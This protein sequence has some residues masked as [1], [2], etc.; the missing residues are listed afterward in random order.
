MPVSARWAAR[1]YCLRPRRISRA[2]PSRG[3]ASSALLTG[4]VT[5]AT[6]GR[7]TPARPVSTG[8]KS[9]RRSHS[10]PDDEQATPRREDHQ[11]RLGGDG[12]T[13][14]L[15]GG[16]D[17]R[18]GSARS[19]RARPPAEQEQR[20]DPREHEGVGG[21]GQQH[22]P[23]VGDHDVE[24]RAVL[25]CGDGVLG[26]RREELLHDSATGS[27]TGGSGSAPMNAVTPT[28]STEGPTPAGH[29]SAPSEAAGRDGPRSV[30]RTSCRQPARSGAPP[31]VRTR[32][33]AR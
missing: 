17:E 9:K 5:P 18:G 14:D 11:H 13:D 22:H 1:E 27:S 28:P 7:S 33:G 16:G 6:T 21:S 4:V 30:E 31:G 23:G 24:I 20:D 25:M 15:G 32:G 10:G 12:R 3:R 29:E 8:P 19:R 26:P 2:R